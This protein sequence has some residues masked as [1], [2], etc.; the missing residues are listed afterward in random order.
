M[1]KIDRT[2]AFDCPL[3]NSGEKIYISIDF[4]GETVICPSC[5]RDVQV[6]AE[7]R[8]ALRQF[9]SASEGVIRNLP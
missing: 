2:V 3:C 1:D 8:E 5:N 4:K 7:W 6:T 9:A